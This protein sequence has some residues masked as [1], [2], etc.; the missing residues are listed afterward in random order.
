[1]SL[2]I[3]EKRNFCALKMSQFIDQIKRMDPDIK[4]L[5]IVDNGEISMCDSTNRSNLSE[6]FG[7]L[8]VTEIRLEE[9]EKRLFNRRQDVQEAIDKVTNENVK[10]VK[11]ESMN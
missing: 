3:E 6:A 5:I 11:K 7:L 1:M 2:T 4:V 9:Q 10:I 8:K